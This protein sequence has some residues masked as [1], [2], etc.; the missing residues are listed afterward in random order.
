MSFA[1]RYT[2]YDRRYTNYNIFTIVSNSPIRIFFKSFRFS[3]RYPYKCNKPCTAKRVNSHL[4][5]IARWP[6]CLSAVSSE[7]MISP[8]FSDGNDMTSVACLL[9]KNLSWS[10]EISTSLVKKISALNSLPP[11]FSKAGKFP[12]RLVLKVGWGRF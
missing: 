8:P 5:G 11:P 9:C 7:I 4:K 12:L 6:A 3:S 1:L 2:I 10:F